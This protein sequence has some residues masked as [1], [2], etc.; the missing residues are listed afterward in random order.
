MGQTCHTGGTGGGLF[1]QVPRTNVD[2]LQRRLAGSGTEPPKGMGKM[3]KFGKDLGK[4]RS[5]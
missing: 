5:G 1:V 3:G 4:G 2:V